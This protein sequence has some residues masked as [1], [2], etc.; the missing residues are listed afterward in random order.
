MTR[1]A[2]L[3]K[4]QTLNHPTLPQPNHRDAPPIPSSSTAV[5]EFTFVVTADTQFGMIHDN[6]S[7]QEEMKY[8]RQAVARINALEPRPL[9]CCVCGDLVHMTAETFTKPYKGK[10]ALSRQVCDKIQ[11]FQAVWSQ[12]HDDIPLVCVCGNH[13]VGDRP[14]PTSI[15]RFRRVYGDDH[16]AFWAQRAYNIVLNTS[17]FNDPSGASDLYEAQWEWLKERLQYAQRHRA[18][19]VFVFGHH[20][21]FLYDE[22]EDNATLTGGSPL[23]QFGLPGSIEDSYFIIPLERR[24]RVL[25]LFEE[26]GVTACFAGHFHQNMVSRTKSGMFMITTSALSVVLE[27]TG[28]PDDFDEPKS[29]G[30][31]VVTAAGDGSFQ[32]YFV[33][34]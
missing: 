9:F 12:I 29:R 7:W 8:S 34:L 17:L 4:N 1:F 14:T 19:H 31:R 21:W 16:L 30:M 13:D 27:S 15:A 18:S 25:A 11:D 20:P 22:D 32:H 6:D 24:K 26:Y 28:I 2:E 33:S 23:E 10:P 5:S 3:Q